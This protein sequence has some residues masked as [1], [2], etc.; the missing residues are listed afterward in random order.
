ME[1][2]ADALLSPLVRRK[3]RKSPSKLRG[4]GSTQSPVPFIKGWGCHFSLGLLSPAC[5]AYQIYSPVSAF[6]GLKDSMNL[7]RLLRMW[8]TLDFLMTLNHTFQL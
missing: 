3:F 1:A 7:N 6:L 8:C 4:A 5:Q 2:L